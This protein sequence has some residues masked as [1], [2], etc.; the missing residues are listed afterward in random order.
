M[1]KSLLKISGI[2]AIVFGVLACLTLVG[3]I[4]G[5]PLIIGG[6]KMK[7]YADYTDEQIIANKDKILIWTIVFLFFCQISGILLLIFYIDSIGKYEKGITGDN[8]N[9]QSNMN[10]NSNAKYEELEKVK[11]L[12]DEK[13]LT[14]EEYEKEKE[15]I[16]N[17]L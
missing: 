10:T 9:Y 6:A 3:A 5:V 7:E 12:Y 2:I 11:K 1:D 16:L 8:M 13:I 15:R 4:V 17:Q 14:K